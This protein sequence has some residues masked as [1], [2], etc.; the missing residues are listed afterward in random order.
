MKCVTLIKLPHVDNDILS[1]N[2]SIDARATSL[3]LV[4]P[5]SYVNSRGILLFTTVCHYSS[6]SEFNHSI[7]SGPNCLGQYY[8]HSSNSRISLR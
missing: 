7:V 8:D 4:C 6:W 1:Q 5:I 3:Q 2:V